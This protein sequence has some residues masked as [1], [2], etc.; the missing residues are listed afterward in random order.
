[1]LVCAYERLVCI[2]ACGSYVPRFRR[3]VCL[4]SLQRTRCTSVVRIFKFRGFERCNLLKK[5]M[6]AY[7][8]SSRIIE[9]NA[10]CQSRMNNGER[11]GASATI[12][13]Q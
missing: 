4:P 8:S 13:S 1:M 5:Y 9:D 10:H 12:R 3:A 7:I 2:D 11:K 6:D